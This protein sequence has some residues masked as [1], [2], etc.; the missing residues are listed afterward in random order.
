MFKLFGDDS[1]FLYRLACVETNFGQNPHTFINDSLNIWAI[2]SNKLAETQNTVKHP[3]LL[4]I[5]YDLADKYGVDWELLNMTDLQTPLY[6]AIAVRLF[7]HISGQSIP[8]TVEDQAQFWKQHYTTSGDVNKFVSQVYTNEDQLSCSAHIDL[9]VVLDGSGSIE[10]KDFQM[11]KDFIYNYTNSITSEN[12]R[13][14]LV[15]FSSNAQ[16]IYNYSE[17]NKNQML[18]KIEN[19][20]QPAGSTNTSGGI[21]TVV[22]IMKPPRPHPR[23]KTMFVLTDGQSNSPPGVEP[24][25]SNAREAHIASWVWGVGPNV[26]NTELL[27]IAYN[28]KANVKPLDQ[29]KELHSNLFEFKSTVCSL[30]LKP[31]ISEKIDDFTKKNEKRYFIF[32][33]QNKGLN[34]TVQTTKGKLIGYYSFS[35][36]KPSSAIHDDQFTDHIYIPGLNTGPTQVFVVMEDHC[37]IIDG[38]LSVTSN[39]FESAK[40]FVINVTKALHSS[41]SRFCLITYGDKVYDIYT[42]KDNI[43]LPTMLSMVENM[44]QPEGN[45]NTGGAIQRAV[46]IFLEASPKPNVAR[47]M[48]VLTDGQSNVPP[49]VEPAVSNAKHNN[50]NSL[51][52]GI[53]TDTN[54]TELLEIAYGFIPDYYRNTSRHNRPVFYT[55]NQKHKI[56]MKKD[57]R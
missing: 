4:L 8:K 12:G 38:S 28:I 17:N 46:D 54:Q 51:V 29:Y 36:S 2:D 20:V 1:G 25:V 43:D 47:H 53:G 33:L 40:H 3:N 35:T 41:D 48:L 45:T 16:T 55:L 31:K 37:I 10:S 42:L 5:Y 39:E 52:W 24:A 6:A 11:A 50:I 18:S 7:I 30:P 26:N 56:F 34:L 21:Q 13:F 44:I 15:L 49:G 14:C 23:N 57:F 22:D 32:D 19:L 9:C 27:E